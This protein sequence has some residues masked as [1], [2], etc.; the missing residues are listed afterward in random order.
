MKISKLLVQH[1]HTIRKVNVAKSARSV[2]IKIYASNSKHTI[3][4]SD[5]GPSATHYDNRKLYNY[6]KKNEHPSAT[7][8]LLEY[9]AR[10]TDPGA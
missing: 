1:G 3:R 8:A 9:L 5:H 4:I 2:Y 10:L 6:P 7:S